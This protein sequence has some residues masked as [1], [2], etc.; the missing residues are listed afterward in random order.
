[1]P[2]YGNGKGG[3]EVTSPLRSEVLKLQA[4][5]WVDRALRQFYNLFLPVALFPGS[6]LLGSLPPHSRAARQSPPSSV[7][8]GDGDR[9]QG[10]PLLAWVRCQ[11]RILDFF[12][13]SRTRESRKD[14]LEGP[15][16]AGEGNASV[17]HGA[18]KNLCCEATAATEAP[19]KMVF[20]FLTHVLTKRWLRGDAFSFE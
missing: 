20:F 17:F 10:F 2:C 6:V 3:D 11:S 16:G 13:R 4:S 14:S 15:P 1:M 19:H 18:T 8:L 7:P 12:S 5:D 9:R